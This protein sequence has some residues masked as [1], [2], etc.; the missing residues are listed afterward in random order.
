VFPF[1]APNSGS[2]GFFANGSLKRLDLGGGAPRTLASATNGGG[3]TWN[4]DD[5]IVFAQ[6]FSSPLL[7][8]SANGGVVTPALPLAPGQ[9]GGYTNP[10]FLPDGRRFLYSA[11]GNPEESGIY[12][13]GLGS[14]VST[15]LTPDDGDAI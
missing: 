13:G 7:Q 8:I 10:H 9:P 1:W 6:N 3:G 12:I 15:R 4:A 14:S 5:V 11:N 2:I